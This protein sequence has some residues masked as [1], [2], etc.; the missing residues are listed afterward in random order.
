MIT[1]RSV[2]ELRRALA[3]ERAAGRR[4]VFVPTM[5]NLHEGHLR[6]VHEAHQQ[7]ETVVASIYVNPLQFGVNEDYA[8]YPRTPEDDLEALERE[9]TNLVFLPNDEEIYP[10][11]KDLQTIVEVP[12]ISDILCG[13]FRPGHFRGV[14]TVV[15][16]LFNL[17]SPDVA[18]FG[19]KDY[20]QL[21]VIRLMTSDLGLPIDIVGIDTVRESDGLAMSS[22]NR[23]LTKKERAQA[24]GL[25]TT[26]KQ[27]VD[28]LRADD[29]RWSKLEAWAERELKANGF[30][31]E[32]VSIRRQ[33]DLA[34]PGSQDRELVILAAAYL[35]KTRLI[36]NIEITR[37]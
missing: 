6:L 21:L 26:L 19:K 35:G 28:Y 12:G 14:T 5:G 22:R 4:I 1:V 2:K 3:D 37:P 18:V 16:R 31:P 20:Q 10:R 15:N 9:K 24:P 27:V 13:E 25:Y 23:Y 30:K 34:P 17:V 8:N 36:D 11:G 33:N 7:G 32:Y 29:T